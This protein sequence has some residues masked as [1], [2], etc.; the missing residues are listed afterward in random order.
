MEKNN[1]D[2]SKLKEKWGSAWVAR[3]QVGVFTGGLV[4]SSTMANHDS[5]RT[6]PKRFMVKNK[7]GYF[8]DDLIEWLEGHISTD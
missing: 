6:G 1:L 4:A 5:F 8:V 7:V 3:N 2:L